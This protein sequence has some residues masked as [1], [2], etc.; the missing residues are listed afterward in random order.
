MFLFEQ[1]LVE[2]EASC[3]AEDTD[4]A[5]RSKKDMVAAEVEVVVEAS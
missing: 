3:Q 1:D 4:M 2:M 5:R